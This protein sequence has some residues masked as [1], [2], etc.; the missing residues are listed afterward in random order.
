[1]HCIVGER[2]RVESQLGFAFDAGPIGRS[3]VSLPFARLLCVAHDVE[4]ACL[5]LFGSLRCKTPPSTSSPQWWRRTSRPS[6]VS[7]ARR[8]LLP[9]LSIACKSPSVV[10][11][12]ARAELVF[13]LPSARMRSEGYST[14]SVSQSVCRS[15]SI[16]A[17]TQLPPDRDQ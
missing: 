12:R 5:S 2:K 3:Y 13:F 6:A 7:D 11:P 17:T 16:L 4:E 15:V 1:M 8:C 9:A 14:W 10:N